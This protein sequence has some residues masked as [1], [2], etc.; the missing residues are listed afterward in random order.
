[1]KTLLTCCF[2]CGFTMIFAAA[3]SGAIPPTTTIGDNDQTTDLNSVRV[4]ISKSQFSGVNQNDA[5][6]ALKIYTQRL[7]QAMNLAISENQVIIED[8][9]GLI[10]LI[11]NKRAEMFTLTTEEF[12]TA[13][14]YGLVGPLLVSTTHQKTTE[15][16][17]LLVH[18]DSSIRK[19]ED[20]QGKNLNISQ[21][22]RAS[23]ARLWLDVLFFERGM[24]EAS[25][26]LS[27]VTPAASSNLVILP[28][29]F[30]QADACV[31]TRD[32]FD[33]IGEL[34][35]QVKKQLRI[36]A[37]SAPL[38]PALTCLRSDLPDSFKREIIVT[39]LASQK[40]P[41]FA[42]LMALFKVEGLSQQP[43][44]VLDSARTLLATHLRYR[45]QSA[46]NQTTKG[47]AP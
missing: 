29:F 4:A 1:M 27:R 42:Q 5:L 7:T 41:G 46:L 30:H 31:V 8:H 39:A 43:L 23:L 22:V 15:E 37:S 34:N 36:V 18:A 14:T 21:N 20:L 33:T 12:L 2:L 6:A 19:M 26:V 24:G 40:Q 35:P 17:L 11:Q 44:A 10:K 47:R 9:E 3:D 25:Q 28:V 13:E 45:D 38:V 16:Y 32:S